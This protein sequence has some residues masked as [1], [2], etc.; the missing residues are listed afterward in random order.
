MTEKT[1]TYMPKNR[2]TDGGDR[3]VI[4]GTLEFGKDAKVENFPGAE[5]VGK[6]TATELSEAVDDFN[7]LLD[8]LK[9]YGIIRPD[10]WAITAGLA[11]T[12]TEE[13]AV[14]NNNAVESV[15]YQDGTVTVTVALDGL[16]AFE[17][18]DASQGTH[19]W[20]AL[21]FGT[22]ISPITGAELNGTPL[23]EQDITDATAAGCAAGSFVLYINAEEAAEE[24]A[25]EAAEEPVAFTLDA[26]GHQTATVRI[27]IVEPEEK[28]DPEETEDTPEDPENQETS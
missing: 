1:D 27:R 3:L 21:E 28:T 19:K 4:G 12:P 15:T 25:E 18:S 11:P 20:I 2:S 8:K 14:A 16:T 10:P 22:G 9:K 23:T 24:E 7:G 26:E 13:Q 5:N 6:S 17:R